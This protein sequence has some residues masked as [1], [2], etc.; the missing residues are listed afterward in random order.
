MHGRSHEHMG[1]WAAAMHGACNLTHATAGPCLCLQSQLAPLQS[2]Q[3]I[4]DGVLAYN[5][6]G[7]RQRTV[8][9]CDA[10]GGTS[11]A[12]DFTLKVST[13]GLVC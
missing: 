1:S 3:S 6:D 2:P 9:W 13:D 11:A 4:A 5:Q 7:H 10:T 12:F 8:D